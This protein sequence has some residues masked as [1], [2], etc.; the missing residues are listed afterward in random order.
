MIIIYHECNVIIRFAF[1]NLFLICRFNLIRAMSVVNGIKNDVSNR[2][3]I[4]QEHDQTI[5][6]H[7]PST[8]WRSPTVTTQINKPLQGTDIH[9]FLRHLLHQNIVPP[10]THTPP[11]QLSYQRR[12]QIKGLAR[13]IPNL[14]HIEG[15]D[16]RWPMGDKRERSVLLHQV[17]FM[18]ASKILSLLGQLLEFKLDHLPRIVLDLHLIPHVLQHSIHRIG[19]LDTYERQLD[20]L[21]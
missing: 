17:L 6:T 20:N 12:Q 3:R 14:L 21:P 18:L 1:P 15:L 13:A 2:S 8:V 4:G 9:L 5:E 16:R 7:P 11:K 19:M 10:F